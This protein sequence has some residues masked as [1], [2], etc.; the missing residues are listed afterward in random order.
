MQDVI[1]V[2]VSKDHL[3]ACHAGSGEHRRFANDKVGL[4]RG[5]EKAGHFTQAQR[6]T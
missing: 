6:L 3:D 4:L 2:D 1:G 5:S